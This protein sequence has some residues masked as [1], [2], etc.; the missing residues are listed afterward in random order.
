[1]SQDHKSTSQTP[2]AAD[3]I[4]A[5]SDFLLDR[6]CLLPV[7]ASRLGS[8]ATFE[9]AIRG[10]SM[11]PAIPKYSRLRVQLLGGRVPARGD[12]LYYLA[13]DGFVIHRLVHQVSPG[14]GQRYYLTIGDNCLAPDAPVSEDRVLG[15]V[16]AVVSTSGSRPPG[17]PRLNS[18]LHRIARSI[19]IPAT[20]AASR[21]SISAGTG[22]ASL[23]RWFEDIG[24]ARVG[25]LLRFVGLS[26]VR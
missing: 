7:V 12:I 14:S 16:I 24:R 25:R 20:F 2:H 19:S 15:V 18:V 23:F 13:N 21:I 26:N 9:S 8:D 17:V 22:V 6:D 5:V 11:A 1:M 4:A 3:R 10:G